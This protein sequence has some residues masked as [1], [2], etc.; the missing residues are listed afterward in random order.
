[1][2]QELLSLVKNNPDP[3]T[4]G[5]NVA[6]ELGMKLRTYRQ[7]CEEG[8][9][10]RDPRDLFMGLWHEGELAA[11]YADTNVGKSILAVQIAEEVA[12]LGLRVLYVDLELSDK[13]V[14]KRSRTET[15][16]IYNFSDNFMR[17]T[18]DYQAI[19]D[20]PDAID[21]SGIEILNRIQTVG[22]ASRVDALI[23]DNITAI[24]AGME[25]G[26]VA[27]TLVNRLLQMR[28]QNNWSVL[29]LAHTPKLDK[30]MPIT[31]DSMAG[32]KRLISLIDSAFA[33]GECLAD[34]NVRYIKQTKVRLDE[35]RYHANNVL[36]CH[37]ERVDGL[38]RFVVQG[39]CTEASML[40][41]APSKSVREKAEVRSL[42]QQGLPIKEICKLTGLNRNRVNYILQDVR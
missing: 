18:I 1:M 15:G 16:E 11:L 28:T 42:F 24:C 3:D 5:R 27:V 9:R 20:D 36:A 22:I 21:D 26:D 14:E 29:F 17:L 4:L 10:I 8:A 2:Q 38:L 34:P 31:R 13:G 32:S 6:D 25:T 41:E 40:T 12:R 39:T 33:I 7:C 23:I 30:K 35:C 37:I 19:A